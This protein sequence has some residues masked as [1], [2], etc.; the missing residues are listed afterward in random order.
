MPPVG[1]GTAASGSATYAAPVV[2]VLLKWAL[3]ETAS[4]PTI[5]VWPALTTEAW[6]PLEKGLRPS[7]AEAEV[8][9]HPEEAAASASAP[10]EAVVL[11]E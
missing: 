2:G 1:T 4:P 8:L 6:C 9:L 7:V 11:Q 5:S 3:P 10:E